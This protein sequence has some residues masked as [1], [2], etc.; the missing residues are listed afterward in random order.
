MNVAKTRRSSPVNS[1]LREHDAS[2]AS[3]IAKKLEEEIVLGRR[4]PRERLI[5]RDL[6]EAFNTHR[7]DV[8]LALFEL[9]KKGMVHRIPNRGAI[10]RDLSPREVREIYDVREDLEVMAVR[11][12]PLPAKQEDIEKLERLQRKHSAAVDASDFLAVYY[13]NVLFHRVLY[14]LCGNLCLIE[15]IEHLAQKVSSI[16]SFAH[17][18]LETLSGSRRDHIEMIEALR[19]SR[20]E[21]LIRLIRCHLQPAPQ[22]YIRAYR[23]RF[24]DGA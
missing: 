20:R 21:D 22:A 6:C 4:H 24:G 13:S 15:T 19:D 12:L 18:N 9:E 7:G 1:E 2:I 16:R 14:G 10:V 5:E 3:K 8:R 23:Q 11:I 17:A